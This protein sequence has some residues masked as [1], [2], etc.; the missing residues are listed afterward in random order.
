M[1]CYQCN[2][3]LHLALLVQCAGCGRNHHC[4]LT[5]LWSL[6]L[7]NGRMLCTKNVMRKAVGLCNHLETFCSCQ[8]GALRDGGSKHSQPSEVQRNH[9]RLRF[10]VCTQREQHPQQERQECTR[11]LLQLCSQPLRALPPFCRS[12]SLCSPA[13]VIAHPLLPSLQPSC[14]AAGFR[15]ERSA[16]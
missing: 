5:S 12:L 11:S 2:K 13:R 10:G 8:W 14:H 3:V 6:V 1:R 16:A 4:S 9:K 7:S 15:Q